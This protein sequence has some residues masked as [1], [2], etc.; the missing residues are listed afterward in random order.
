MESHDDGV[1]AAFGKRYTAAELEDSVDAA[2]RAGCRRFD[3]YF[4]TGL[5]TQTARSVRDTVPY[6]ERLYERLGERADRLLAFTSPM[7]PTLDPGSMVFDDPER[8]GYKLRAR[9]LEEHRKLLVQP[10]WKHILNYEPDAMTRDELVDSTYEA[11]IG[12]TRVKARYGAV[13]ESAAAV[14]EARILR[15]RDAMDLIDAIVD[16]DPV[17]RARRLARLKTEFD[18][19]NESTVCEKNELEW[20]ARARIGNVV[21]VLGL[22]LRETLSHARRGLRAHTRPGFE[23]TEV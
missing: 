17:L 4:M 14:T 19:L 11:G 6:V 21:N 20:P 22:W 18:T 5:P 13:S 9:T 1:R 16:G 10:S 23:R 3:L 12:L 8:W 2:L 15:A 7:A